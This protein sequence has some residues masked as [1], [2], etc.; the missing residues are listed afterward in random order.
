MAQHDQFSVLAHGKHIF[1]ADAQ[2]FF[3]DINSRFQGKNHSFV[4]R[5]GRIVGI[6]DI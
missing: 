1:N 5:K 3:R 4:Q 2:L 6:M